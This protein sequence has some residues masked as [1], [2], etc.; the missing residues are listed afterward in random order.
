MNQQ[1]LA[2]ALIVLIAGPTSMSGQE[3]TAPAP[4]TS[5]EATSAAV[6]LQ[7]TETEADGISAELLSVQ[8]T[9]GDTLTIKFR[10]INT[11]KEEIEV[12]QVLTNYSPSNLAEMIYYIDGK[13]KKKYSVLKDASNVSVASKMSGLKLAGG[14][15]KAGWA[16]LPAPPADVTSI[17]VMFPG[18]PPFE[19]VKVAP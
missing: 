5:S 13:N 12:S 4:S 19:A 16:K 3:E 9:E 10:F 18:T 1:I 17:T 14:G 11:T 6:P 8:R 2:I 7:K 15:A